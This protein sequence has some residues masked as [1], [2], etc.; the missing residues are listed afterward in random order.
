ML[1]RPCHTQYQIIKEHKNQTITKKILI[2]SLSNLFFGS[3]LFIL[4]FIDY[5][6]P[7]FNG[8]Y[9]LKDSKLKITSQIL[10]S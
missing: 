1:K 9:R 5:C 8:K 4:L 6:H 3:K 10:L 2:T 7:L